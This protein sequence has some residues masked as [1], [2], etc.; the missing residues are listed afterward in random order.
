MANENAAY[1][2][3][4]YRLTQPVEISEKDFIEKVKILDNNNFANIHDLLLTLY[5]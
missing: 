5:T 3:S 4:K 1:Y 2:Q